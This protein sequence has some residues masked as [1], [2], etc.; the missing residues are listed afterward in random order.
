MSKTVLFRGDHEVGEDWP[1]WSFSALNTYKTCPY[2]YLHEKVLKTVPYIESDAARD[3]NIIHKHFEERL[4]DGTQF[5]KKIRTSAYISPDTVRAY[6]RLAA[7]LETLSKDKMTF[8]ETRMALSHTGEPVAYFS[9]RP[10][11][12]LRLVVDFGYIDGNVAHI[13]DYKTGKRKDDDL[14]LAL[15]FAAIRAKYPQVTEARV[16]FV[17]LKYIKDAPRQLLSTGRYTDAEEY[18]IW[19]KCL[20]TVRSIH[21]SM[22]TDSWPKRKSGLCRNYCGVDDCEHRNG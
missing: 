5:P 13:Y 4:R 17:W 7:R 19:Q 18:G 22:S 9:K 6:E 11:V 10:K 12:F 1:A 8:Y 3:G 16:H 2:K 15:F 20:D 21:Q 14:Q